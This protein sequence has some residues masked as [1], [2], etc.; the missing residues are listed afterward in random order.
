M[1]RTAGFSSL[2][3]NIGTVRRREAK[4]L[5][6]EGGIA[7]ELIECQRRGLAEVVAQFHDARQIARQAD[8]YGLEG[9]VLRFGRMVALGFLVLM[10][11]N[12]V[13]LQRFGLLVAVTMVTSAA[14]A[15]TLL[16][17]VMLIVHRKRKKVQSTI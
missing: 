11:S 4:L 2:A 7:F 9:A 15:L 6:I 17:A 5:G 1:I 8:A 12:L 10:L 16:P 14:A 13:P 3:D